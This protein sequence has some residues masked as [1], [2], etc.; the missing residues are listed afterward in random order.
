MLGHQLPRPLPLFED[1]WNTLDDVFGWLDGTRPTTL[2]PRAQFMD[3]D[4]S[5][6]A[7]SAI[8]TWRRGVPLELI[9]YA[10]AN[11]LKVDIDYR[12]ENGRW[13][14]RRVAPYSFRRT[15]DGN[16]VLFVV[17]DRGQ[18]RS[19][20]LDRIAGVRP[21]SESFAPAFRVEF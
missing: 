10:G 3:T 17:N 20:R 9:R 5:W 13:G 18:L 16:I 6:R 11:R 1:F 8:T 7:P 4:P 21:T 2:L 15:R 12:A 14:S 19:Y